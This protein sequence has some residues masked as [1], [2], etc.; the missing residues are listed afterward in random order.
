MSDR[1]DVHHH[2]LPIDYVRCTH[3][4][5]RRRRLPTPEGERQAR[6]QRHGPHGISAAVL[7]L[8]A[9][10]VHFGDTPR[11]PPRPPGE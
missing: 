10:G 1:I 9:P 4:A 8:A 6:H 3:R 7:S 11:Q 2:L 5:H